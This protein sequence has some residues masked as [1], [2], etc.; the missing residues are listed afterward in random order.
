MKT[1]RFKVVLG[2][3]EDAEGNA[4]WFARCPALESIGGATSD[5]PDKKRCAASTNL[6]A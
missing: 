6:S 2:P 5:A 4:A 1:Y 3:D